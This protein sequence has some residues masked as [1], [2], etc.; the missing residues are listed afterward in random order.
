MG[1]TNPGLSDSKTQVQNYCMI[2]SL[3]D[4]SYLL[5]T[6]ALEIEPFVCKIGFQISSFS[7]KSRYAIKV[8]LI[9][10]IF[11]HG[12]NKTK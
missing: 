1:D 12:E 9:C 10:K 8:S 2:L 3:H 7:C 6:K 11:I 5:N 4:T